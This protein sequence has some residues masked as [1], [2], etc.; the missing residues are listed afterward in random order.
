[1]PPFQDPTSGLAFKFFIQKDLPE[2]LQAELC[3]TIAS[4]GGRVE[5]KVPRAGF[6]LINP[7]TPEEE[8]LRL[9]WMS[10][11]RP[12]RYFVPYT[13]V[14]ACKVANMLLKQIFLEEGVPIPMHIHSSIANPNARS[15]LSQRIIHSG[16]DPTASTSSARV[17][18]ADPNTD[19]FKHLVQ[20]YQ[21]DPNK[22]IESYLWVKKS[23]ERGFLV[24]TPL[25]YK[26]PGGRRAGEDRV[27][28]TDEDEHNL[29]KW[30]AFT[31]PR[32]ETGGRTG[33]VIYKQLCE[34]KDEPEY[35]WVQ[36]H[37]WQSWRERYKKHAAR[38]DQRIAAIVAEAQPAPNAKG[39]YGYVRQAEEKPKRRRKKKGSSP[40]DD[41]QPSSPVAGPSS[42]VQPRQGDDEDESEWA[43]RVGT[44]PP[45]VWAGK[46]RKTRS[47]HGE[48][49]EEVAKRAKQSA[50]DDEQELTDIAKEFQ[51]TKD[52]VSAYYVASRDMDK[53]RARF[54]KMRELLA[55]SDFD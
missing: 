54:K 46:K 21:S 34:K 17:I 50:R 49:D 8:R 32:K 13:F 10:P 38:L 35:A 4:L 26:N 40:S 15:A 23:I 45:P 11:D 18:L 5:I 28:F 33:N 3:E 47:N 12:E 30:I 16:G 39:Q 41:E 6:I 36:R 7:N 19:V 42:P 43:V 9:C 1:M 14:D 37:S 52:E 31:I 29:A 24:Y 22:Y 25:V 48:S 53:T 44:E 27:Q 20:T 2:T 55:T 51:F